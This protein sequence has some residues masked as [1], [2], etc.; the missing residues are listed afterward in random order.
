M[1]KVMSKPQKPS[2][3]FKPTSACTLTT[4][5]VAGIAGAALLNTQ[6]PS[7]TNDITPYPADGGLYPVGTTP[8]ISATTSHAVAATPPQKISRQEIQDSFIW[9]YSTR[10]SFIDEAMLTS[11]NR[12]FDSEKIKAAYENPA[13]SKQAKEFARIFFNKYPEILVG[14]EKADPGDNVDQVA[15]LKRI[16]VDHQDDFKKAHA[17]GGDEALIK[18]ARTAFLENFTYS[19]AAKHMYR[20]LGEQPPSRSFG[21]PDIDYGDGSLGETELRVRLLRGN[22]HVSSGARAVSEC[23]NDASLLEFGKAAM[24]YDLKPDLENARK[25]I[26][27]RRSGGSH[28]EGFHQDPHHSPSKREKDMTQK[29]HDAEVRNTHGKGHGGRG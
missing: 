13:L 8:W 28:V 22:E 20:G 27:Q 19:Y 16:L 4:L 2:T 9:D 1:P 10:I 21:L 3:K 15:S 25:D 12:T 26:A 18:S 11:M 24:A 17:S 14:N 29:G 23:L 5:L 7:A 6:K